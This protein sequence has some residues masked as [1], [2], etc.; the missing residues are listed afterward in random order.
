MYAQMTPVATNEMVRGMKK[1]LLKKPAPF[2]PV[3]NTATRSPPM[4][5]KASVKTTHR[6]VFTIEVPITRSVNMVT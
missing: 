2:T 1:M 5:G 3:T 6:T 4:A